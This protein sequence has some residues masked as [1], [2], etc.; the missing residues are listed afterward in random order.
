[1]SLF[2]DLEITRSLSSPPS[3]TSHCVACVRY[4][5]VL[6]LL[7]S[8]ATFS[9]II[10]SLSA[11]QMKGKGSSSR[12]TGSDRH[13][14]QDTFGVADGG[15]TSISHAVSLSCCLEKERKNPLCTI[16]YS[17]IMPLTSA[18]AAIL[19]FLILIHSFF[20]SLRLHRAPFRKKERQF[21]PLALWKG[22][23]PVA[24]GE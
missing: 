8:S 2:A 19:S 20:P 3:V 12:E 9:F 10:L 6:L 21:V 18:A 23:L 13:D 4:V 22:T 5:C 1:M 7:P 11:N 14:K 16:C 15:V 24:S 17:D